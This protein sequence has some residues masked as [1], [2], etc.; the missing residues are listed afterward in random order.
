MI[1]DKKGENKKMKTVPINHTGGGYKPIPFKKKMNSMKKVLLGKQLLNESLKKNIKKLVFEILTNIPKDSNN[2]L[3]EFR[4][5][6]KRKG[7][8]VTYTQ[9]AGTTF[10][11]IYLNQLTVEKVNDDTHYDEKPDN[12][13][14]LFGSGLS[15]IKSY[16]DGF[17][18]RC[19]VDGVWQ[20]WNTET[21]EVIDI[22]GDGDG[23]ILDMFLPY[24]GTMN[25]YYNFVNMA[26]N[27]ISLVDG[28][29]MNYR[30][31]KF[32]VS[33]FSNT[34]NNELSL[35]IEPY[36]IE[37]KDDLGKVKTQPDF[38]FILDELDNQLS[39]VILDC[40]GVK[41]GDHKVKFKDIKIGKLLNMPEGFPTIGDRPLIQLVCEESIQHMGFVQWKGSYPVSVNNSLIQVSVSKD[42]IRWF[43]TSSDKMEGLSQPFES[44]IQ[45]NMKK[46][47]LKYYPDAKTLEV[48]S[49][50]WIRDV[51]V[52]DRLGKKQSD[53]FRDT[54]GLGFMNDMTVKQREKLVHM[55]WSSGNNR[56]DFLIWLAENAKVT[57]KT[58]CL[59][60]ECKRNGFKKSDMNQLE[61]Y[62][63]K[64]KNAIR[65]LGTSVNITENQIKYWNGSSSEINGS[66]QLKNHI[67]FDLIDLEEWGFDNYMAE[68]HQRA[69]DTIENNKK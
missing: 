59:I 47:L 53:F 69:L 17:N 14:S 40:I 35:P 4:V 62:L 28:L 12:N 25:G 45:E 51:I 55:E 26:R 7:I 6:K 5:D 27:M 43:F 29:N 60:I 11:T 56:F 15:T 38:T 39:E 13:G 67:D 8:H 48:A 18:I 36:K 54:F 20:E 61:D 9:D 33:G 46:W 68:Y 66:G 44:L 58:Y 37:W 49:Q 2:I 50:W 19:G 63:L 65:C 21:T 22:D 52:D 41:D 16:T 34:E 57:D 64:T 42:D 30:T 23:F 3:W 1:N 10:E 32:I 31:H 24:T